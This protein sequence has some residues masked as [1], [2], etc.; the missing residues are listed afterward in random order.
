M[1]KIL[2]IALAGFFSVLSGAPERNY[3]DSELGM[4]SRLTAY[5]LRANH[6]RP[7]EM[8]TVFSHKFFNEYLDTLDP[9]RIYF[10]QQDVKQFVR[11]K[12]NLGISLFQGNT[13]FAF[14]LYERY[15]QRLAEF[16]EFAEKM[17]AEKQDFTADEYWEIK[18]DKSPR[19]VDEK[20]QKELW[21]LRVKND[22]LYYHL[23]DR[24]MAEDKNIKKDKK[25]EAAEAAWKWAGTTPEKCLLKRLRD[26]SN[27]VMKKDRIDILGIYLNALAQV[28]GPHSNYYAPK[29]SEDFDIQMSLS[30]TGIGA[31]LSSDDG[32]IKVVEIVPGGPASRDG[33]LRIEDR[34]AIAV[35]SNL[36]TTNLIDLPVSQAVRYIRGPKD[37]KVG[38]GILTDKRGVN[39]VPV[40]KLADILEFASHMT[41]LPDISGS[42]PEWRG[43]IYFR[44]Y[45]LTRSKVELTDSGAKG[46]IREV[47]D[48]NGKVKKIGVLELPSFYHDFS[49]LR[50]GDAKAK[51]CSVDV[52]NILADFRKNKVD[53]VLMDLRLNGGGSL[54]EAIDMTG[55]FTHNGPVVQV[56]TADNAIEVE[57][58]RNKKISYTGPLVILT[59]KMSASAS[60]IFTAALQDSSRALVL[61]D[62]RTFG[63]GTILKVEDLAPHFRWL[64][65]KIPGGTV[66]FEM[67][68]F[69]RING[70]S[71]QQLGITP[72]IQLPSFTEELKIGEMFLDHHLPW[73]KIRPLTGRLYDTDLK[74]KAKLLKEISDKRIAASSDYQLLNKRIANYRAHKNRTHISL[75][76]AKRWAEYRHEKDLDDE[77][78]RLISG[79]SEVRKKAKHNDPV[80]TEAIH[81]AADYST[82]E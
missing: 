82:L 45:L 65:A 19:P 30:L 46:S 21:R 39:P 58:S 12:V 31:T 56:R 44:P 61:G 13:E 14:A 15:R 69:F 23:L 51:R 7:Q 2:L 49:A 57:R 24:A 78:E 1:K 76:E 79:D 25:Q 73:D 80:L 68:M 53:A 77:A 32:F 62:S 37:S 64:A 4:I 27:E 42:F 6:Y 29:L 35:Q 71:V 8:N 47:K 52:D 72:D 34:I 60:E 16:I 67:A 54:S 28:F 66:S 18:R 5:I 36:E 59:S 81:I 10:T 43:N 20:A 9:Q 38:L 3:K 70:E 17:C 74:R 50:R 26:I 22:L 63:K 48:K 41:G 33:R 55:L 40:N 75:N 11:Y